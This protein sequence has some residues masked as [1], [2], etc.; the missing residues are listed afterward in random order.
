MNPLA[1]IINILIKRAL[2]W[3]RAHAQEFGGDP[4]FIAVTGGSAGGHLSSL[5]ALTANRPELQPGFEE[6]DTRVAACVPF[7]G[8][9]DFL[10]RTR[11][12]A[13]A[14]MQGF[15]TRYVMP[16]AP[17]ADPEVWDLASPIAQVCEDAPPFFVIHGTHDSLAVVEGAQHFVRALLRS[18]WP[19]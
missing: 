16:A 6:V 3:T 5:L 13:H 9:Y 4:N 2:A 14:P 8:V 15:L 10:D 7:Y 18:A 19:P 17:E 1:P 12:R 11:A